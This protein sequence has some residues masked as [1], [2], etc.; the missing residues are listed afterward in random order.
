MRPLLLVACVV[1]SACT[2]PHHPKREGVWITTPAAMVRC[3]QTPEG[4]VCRSDTAI[5]A[6]SVGH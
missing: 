1:L 3:W 5:A 4:V 6:E 2:T